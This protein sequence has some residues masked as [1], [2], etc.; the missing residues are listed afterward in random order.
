[1]IGQVPDTIADR[2]IVVPMSRKLVTETCAPI[3]ELNTTEIK[4]KCARFALDMAQFISEAGKI[5]G[6]GLND[7]AADTFDPLYVIA[8]LAGGGWEQKLHVAALALNA[9]ASAKNSSSELLLDIFSIF[10]QSDRDK[11]L[12]RELVV[13][14]REGNFG[15]KSLALKYSS[16]NEYRIAQILRTYGI[17]PR[18]VRIGKDVGKGYVASD[19]EEAV[20]RYIPCADF[21]ARADE[22]H[23][24]EQ[25]QAEARIEAQKEAA[26]IEQVMAAAPKDRIMT[27]PETMALILKIRQNSSAGDN[28]NVT[29][30]NQPVTPNVTV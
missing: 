13:T 5:R 30:C 2:S 29:G 6:E 9:S 23:R 14:L 7:R 26:L 22:L 24:Q 28:D 12:T 3:A 21:R 11:L 19:F 17:R 4:S 10:I 27:M 1:M 25:L 16:I 18:A 20:K 8:R 15:M